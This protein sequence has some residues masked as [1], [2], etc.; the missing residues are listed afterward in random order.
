MLPFDCMR[1]A[2][3]ETVNSVSAV[4]EAMAICLESPPAQ[5]FSCTP[6][7]GL[8]LYVVPCIAEDTSLCQLHKSVQVHKRQCTRCSNLA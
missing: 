7:A 3:P 4:A 5:Y 1:A 8:A 2:T 6:Q